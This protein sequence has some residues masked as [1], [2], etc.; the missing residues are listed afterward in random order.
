MNPGVEAACTGS[1]PQALA[2]AWI[3]AATPGSVASPETTSTSGI[4][5]TGLKKCMPT[6]RPGCRSGD[7]MAVIEIDDVFDAR[8]HSGA[9]MLSSRAKSSRLASRSS[10][11]ASTTSDTTQASGSVTTVV[12]RSTAAAAA[13]P[14]SRP[15][16][17]SLFSASAMPARAASAA[18]KRVS[19]SWTRWPASAAIWAMP[20]PIVPAPMTAT[21]ASRG[22]AAAPIIA[23]AFSG[24]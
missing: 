1:L 18:P 5:G 19:W 4:N 16:A 22:S 2:V 14:S 23:S 24:R 8:M 12:M 10:T 11:I 3:A 13:P 6:T 17:A 20:A 15:L 7:A 9:T 21:L